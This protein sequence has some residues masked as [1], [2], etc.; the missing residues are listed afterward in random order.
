MFR[1][2]FQMYSYFSLFDRTTKLQYLYKALVGTKD[3]GLLLLMVTAM[4]GMEI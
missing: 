4:V 3:V 1:K 2:I